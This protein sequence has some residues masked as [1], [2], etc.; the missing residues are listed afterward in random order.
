[1]SNHDQRRPLEPDYGRR[2]TN[3]EAVLLCRYAKAACPQQQFDAYTPDAWSD[4]LG[5]LRFED[6]K[7]AVKNIVQRQPF[8]APAEIR[9]EVRRVRNKRIGDF[10]PIPDPPPGLDWTPAE[11]RDWL[12]TTLRKIGDGE[13]F[14]PDMLDPFDALDRRDVIGELGQAGT[15]IAEDNAATIRKAREAA[16]AARREAQAARKPEPEPLLTP[17]EYSREPETTRDPAAIAAR[18]NAHCNEETSDV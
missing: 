5:D 4:L 2:M 13:V 18:G 7:E 12:A 11:H 1:M 6:C 8:V 17:D 3:A 14:T 10:G 15:S 16:A 9:D